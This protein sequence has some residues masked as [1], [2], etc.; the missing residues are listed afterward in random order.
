[1]LHPYTHLAPPPCLHGSLV[2]LQCAAVGCFSPVRCLSTTALDHS[3]SDGY[4]WFP[5]GSDFSRAA[6]DALDRV[7]I[8]VRISVRR[9]G[10]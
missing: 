6:K 10:C 5:E 9:L 8:H 4:K 3:T 2:M 7:L 1:M